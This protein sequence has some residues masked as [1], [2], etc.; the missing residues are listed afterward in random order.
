MFL[1]LFLILCCNL[2]MSKPK[3]LSGRMM[4]SLVN[5]VRDDFNLRSDF[6]ES[7][8]MPFLIEGEKVGTVKSK[9]AQSLQQDFPLV[10]DRC[11]Q[12]KLQFVP[13]LENSS[14]ADRTTAFAEVTEALRAQGGIKGWRDE[15][16]P[17]SASFNCN[18]KLKIERAACPYF[19]IKAYGVHVNGFVRDK[20]SQEIS[21]MWVATRAKDKSTWPG[22]LDNIVAGQSKVSNCSLLYTN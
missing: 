5:F 3:I 15:L 7:N 9:F 18:I 12:D 16:L 6:F 19:G 10:F 4:N 17:V 1:L 14:L 8:F 22:M 21:N 11:K 20:T 13:N 2:N